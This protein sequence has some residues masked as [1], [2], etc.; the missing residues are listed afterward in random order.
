MLN[1]PLSMAVQLVIKMTRKVSFGEAQGRTPSLSSEAAW[2]SPLDQQ[3]LSKQVKVELR[4]VATSE[5]RIPIEKDVALVTSL[6]R[7]F[8]HGGHL[9]RSSVYFPKI[10]KLW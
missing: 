2:P 1:Y 4:D 5:L 6:K 9:S 10:E 7:K 3:T 8:K